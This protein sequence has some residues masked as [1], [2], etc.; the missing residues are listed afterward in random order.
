[1]LA[2]LGD[3]RARGA[4]LAMTSLDASKPVRRPHQPVQDPRLV[5]EMAAIGDDV[6]LNL[7]P[8]LFQFPRRARR[9][10]AV[11]AALD[12]HAGNAAQLLG[13]GQ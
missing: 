9:G 5:V 1:M 12:D 2:C 3:R 6:E 13:S 10:A 4:L 11:V 8:R 7:G